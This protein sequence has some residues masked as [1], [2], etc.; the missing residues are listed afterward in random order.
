MGEKSIAK[1]VESKGRIDACDF[2]RFVSA[3]GI[4]IYHV[5]CSLP[6]GGFRPLYTFANGYW[7]SVFVGMFLI[8]SGAMMYY[9]KPQI[10]SLRVFYYKRWKAIYP[11]FYMAYLVFYLQNVFANGAFFYK[12]NPKSMILSILGV[13]GYFLYKGD[14][15]YILGDWFLGAII[16]LYV[17]HPLLLW[18]FNRFNKAFGV[19]MLLLWIWQL[20]FGNFEIDDYTNLIGCMVYFVCGM[21]IMKYKL[22][23]KRV[24]GIISLIGAIIIGCVQL[25]MNESIA[26]HL[27]AIF[28]WFVLFYIGKWL[29]DKSE[30]MKKGLRELSS[31][32]YAMFLLQHV[33]IGQAL[34]GFRP[35]EPMRVIAL[36]IFMVLLVIVY[37]KA[38]TVVNGAVVKSKFFQK[39]DGIFLKG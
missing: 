27:M 6:E 22:Y 23:E 36:N 34:V 29:T 32:T 7:G 16:L 5:S 2:I 33:L 28:S 26:T 15:Y 21:Y 8:L 10:D 39:L 30:A 20:Y 25:P 38:L 1:P 14:N 37:A 31:I 35:T 18:L 3:L 12:G 19:G 9:T 11:M 4:I 13:D 24:L 17:L